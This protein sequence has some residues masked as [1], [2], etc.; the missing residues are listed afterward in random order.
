VSRRAAVAI[1]AACLVGGVVV[2]VLTD[3]GI[4]VRDRPDRA[5]PASAGTNVDAARW[6]PP[7]E[8]ETSGRAGTA[9]EAV[10][11]NASRGDDGS[12]PSD[13]SDPPARGPSRRSPDRSRSSEVDA[14][15]ARSIIDT[16]VPGIVIPP[17]EGQPGDSGGSTTTSEPPS[18]TTTTEPTTT[19][20]SSVPTDPG[21][22]GPIITPLPTRTP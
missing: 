12:G 8:D 15:D 19:T 22:S 9:R 6:K 20:T 21:G 14:S 5:D 3:G 7:G 1:W 17:F 13:R 18:T 4:V 16:I 10:A 2:G 11:A